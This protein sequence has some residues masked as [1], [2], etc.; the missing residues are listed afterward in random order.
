[1]KHILA[2]DQGTTGTTTVLYDERGRIAD[3]A[4]REL[5]QIFPQPGWVEHD[6]LEIWR[7]VVETVEEIASRNSASIAAVGVTNQRETTI[8][9][10]RRTGAPI[11]NAIVWQCRRTADLCDQL[12]AHEATFR[13]KTGLPLD[14]YFSGTKIKW[15]LEN[16]VAGP[17]DDMICGTVDAWL[18]WKLTNGAVHATDYT[19]ASR[20]LLFNIMEKQWDADLCGLLDVPQN[21]L[22]E[23]KRSIDDYGSVQ[24]IPSLA[25]VPI[26][27]VAGDQQAALFG[28]T[29]FSPGEAKNTYG[30]GCFLLMNIGASP[31]RSEHGLLT[32]L[33][34]DAAGSPCYASEGSIFIAGAAIQWLRD[35]LG[36]ISASSESEAAAREVE[37][38][39]GVYFVPAF[40]GLGAPHWNAEA[41]GAIVGLTRGSNRGHIVRAALEAMAYQTADVLA[42]MEQDTGVRVERLA[43]DGGASANNLLMQFQADIINR[44]VVRPA[45]IESTSQGAAFL[46]GLGAGV[47]RDGDALRGLREIDAEFLPAMTPERRRAL[48]EGWRKALR[49]VTAE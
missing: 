41:R 39:G 48:L 20:T 44:P 23:V 8:L 21:L 32:T 17:A 42:A 10:N 46:A 27:G 34:A 9:W 14:P 30:T 37:D 16:V 3:K 47:W 33:A 29:C 31:A 11:H 43:V 5:P 36:V 1:M 38:N 13:A 19:N 26:L 28:Q 35:Q 40:V 45:V 15:L 12:R 49:Q 22:P 24:A 6:P 2:I 18:I 4:Y 25:G 7:T